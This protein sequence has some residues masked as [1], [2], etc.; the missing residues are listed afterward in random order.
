MPI[1]SIATRGRTV[2]ALLVAASVLASCATKVSERMALPEETIEVVEVSAEGASRSNATEAHIQALETSVRQQ[3]R[4][5]N[6]VGRKV[7]LRLVI[8]RA[9]FVAQGTR[10]LAGMLAGSNKMDVTVYL[11]EPG[12]L[13]SVG[14]FSV[15][16][17]NNPG[18][19]GAFSDPVVQVA[20]D[21]AAAIAGK[22]YSRN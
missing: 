5:R 6:R 3:V 11:V 7:D 9:E 16:V 4:T 13:T 14:E 12:T 22:V 18:G 1:S 19:F 8:T 15:S 20:D 21:A 17:D 2:G 10:I